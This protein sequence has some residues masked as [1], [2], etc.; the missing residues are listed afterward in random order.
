[1]DRTGSLIRTLFSPLIIDY[2]E[3]IA[4]EYVCSAFLLIIIP[5]YLR[6]SMHGSAWRVV[7]RA[8]AICVPS[9]EPRQSKERNTGS[10]C[11]YMYN[12]FALI[13]LFAFRMAHYPPDDRYCQVIISRRL[14]F[15]CASIIC[16]AASK[17][18]LVCCSKNQC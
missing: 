8:E 4:L 7:V 10:M 6:V 14:C 17:N 13:P 9:S 2:R 15:F 3:C 18:I 16:R 1:M 12:P 11:S 5:E